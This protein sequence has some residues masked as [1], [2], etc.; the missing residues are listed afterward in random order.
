MKRNKKLFS[1]KIKNSFTKSNFETDSD[2]QIIK[3]D[4]IRIIRLV[5]KNYPVFKRKIKKLVY[6]IFLKNLVVCL[7]VRFNGSLILVSNL[8]SMR[9][10]SL[11]FNLI[12]DLSL[13][14]FIYK[15]LPICLSFS[16]LTGIG[17]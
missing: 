15:L 12:A 10:I 1:S 11:S 14:L 16:T 7:K 3:K 5:P 17:G 6:A 9:T 13:M 2:A 8:D 4:I